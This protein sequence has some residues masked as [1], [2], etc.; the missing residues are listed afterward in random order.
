MKKASNEMLEALKKVDVVLELVDARA[1]NKT[2]NPFFKQVIANKPSIRVLMK[3]D[4]A[5]LSKIKL[6]SN[7]VL[8]S[9][10]DKKSINN[11]I[12]KIEES[13]K[14]KKDKAISRGINPLPP[15]AMIVGI[16][17]I[18]KS[19][20]IN[21]LIN[22][23]ITKVENKP[24]LTKNNR[25][26]NVKD[27]FYLLDT[28]GI[29]PS[30]YSSSNYVLAL[31][32]AI[33]NEVLPIY[34]LSE[35]AYDYIIKNYKDLYIKRYKEIKNTSNESFAFIEQIRGIKNDKT[36][37]FETARSLFLKDIRDGNLGRLYFE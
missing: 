23:K 2:S 8:L 27:K 12:N 30:N 15:K 24:G 28:P 6:K 33:K 4:L 37:T 32:G 16:P 1:P 35:F 20:L 26:V 11:L 29:L 5:D 22:R 36:S 17:N 21:A 13:Y 3:S 10:K 9:I 18:G 7:D 19:S 25:W 34:E 14:T 31:I